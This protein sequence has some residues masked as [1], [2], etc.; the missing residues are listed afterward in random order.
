MSDLEELL[1]EEDDCEGC[2]CEDEPEY[3]EVECPSCGEAVS[4]TSDMIDCEDDIEIL[5]P[6]CD[7]VVYTVEHI[8][9]DDEDE[10][11]DED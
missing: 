8:D 10:E 5:C 3:F 6:N 2:S 1:D 11:E 9:A 7:A 4:F